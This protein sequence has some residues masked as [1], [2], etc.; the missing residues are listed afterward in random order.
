[1]LHAPFSGCMPPLPTARPA[2]H[3]AVVAT[4]SPTRRRCALTKHLQQGGDG[5]LARPRQRAGA[6]RWRCRPGPTRTS[7]SRTATT[8]HRITVTSPT[9][10]AQAHDPRSGALRRDDPGAQGRQAATA[11]RPPARGR[12][13]STVTAATTAS[14][15]VNAGQTRGAGGPP[16]TTSPGRFPIGLVVDGFSYVVT[17]PDPR[18]RDRDGQRGAGHDHRRRGA[19]PWSSATPT[20]RSPPPDGRRR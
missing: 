16:A 15:N 1:M 5:H 11:R 10:T 19:R 17:E 6:A 4:R 12:S 18:R 8:P 20:P 9:E 7:T 2:P 3:T 13:S 14:A